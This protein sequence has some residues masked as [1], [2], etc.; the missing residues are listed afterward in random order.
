VAGKN[1]S[2]FGSTVLKLDLGSFFGFLI[3]Y[4]V[5]TTPWTGDQ[6]VAR[7]LRRHKTT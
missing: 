4:T 7:P 6:P 1:L 2:V 5:S 3:L